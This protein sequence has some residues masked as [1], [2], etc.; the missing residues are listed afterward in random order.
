VSRKEAGAW[1]LLIV[2]WLGLVVLVCIIEGESVVSIHNKTYSKQ[3]I[4]S[5]ADANSALV[6][7][8]AGLRQ[9]GEYEDDQDYKEK[10]EAAMEMAEEVLLVQQKFILKIGQRVREIPVKFNG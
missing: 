4:M 1:L 7:L 10:S 6:S 5:L 8:A 2:F 9:V 3:A